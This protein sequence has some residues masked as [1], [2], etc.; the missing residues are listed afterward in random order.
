MNVI[1]K[2]K[3]VAGYLLSQMAVILKPK[4]LFTWA[5]GLKAP[6]YCDNRI[7]VSHPI[8]RH[9]IGEMFANLVKQRHLDVEVIAGVST[10]GIPWATI[11][12]E[13]MGLPMIYV[14]AEAKDHGRK[15]LIEG[16]LISGQKVVVIEDL[17]S[18]GGSSL[19]VVNNIIDEGGIVLG[20]VGIF[21][22]ELPKAIQKFQEANIP[23]A[24]LTNY[25]ILVEKAIEE[26]YVT[27]EDLEFLS[28]WITELR[29]A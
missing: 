28:K 2:A 6:I 20:L 12:A 8:I 27:Q 16:K 21:S 4:D 5:S 29:A 11:V 15:N 3:K 22:Y 24:T 26:N 18:T 14:R 9:E 23:F 10:S 19:K 13:I 1:E 25:D 7:L 17:I